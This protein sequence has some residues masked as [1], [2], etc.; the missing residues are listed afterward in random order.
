[1]LLL[2]GIDPAVTQCAF[3][4]GDSCTN[5][6]S[7]MMSYFALI[8]A[9]MQRYDPKV[10][11]GTLV[12]T[13]LPYDCLPRRFGPFFGVGWN[14]AFPWVRSN[15]SSRPRRGPIDDG[16]STTQ[17]LPKGATPSAGALGDAE[18]FIVGHRHA[19][20]PFPTCP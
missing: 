2:A 17:F 11:L 20:A 15:D 7:P 19:K 16:R 14:S 4:I 13:M 6:I 10:G 9:F 8:M 3:R 5:V 12:A 18:D 1:M